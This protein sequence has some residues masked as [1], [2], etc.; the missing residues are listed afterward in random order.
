MT[1]VTKKKR[2]RAKRKSTDP[3]INGITLRAPMLT[4]TEF[5][6][7]EADSNEEE[8]LNY[9]CTISKYSNKAANV[10]AFCS[11]D[12]SRKYGKVMDFRFSA[13][14]IF[15][16]NRTK[17][18]TEKDI[19][20]VMEFFVRT[21]AWQAFRYLFSVY[22]DQALLIVPPLPFYPDITWTLEGEPT[23]ISTSS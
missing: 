22:S 3:I 17:L 14:Y 12:V 6:R 18:H 7:G 21:S 4:K 23:D 1:E 20:E 11:F 19:D 13:E 8:S 5:E 15:S 10:Y 9:D 2:S 16:V